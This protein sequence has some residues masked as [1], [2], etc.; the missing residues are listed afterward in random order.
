MKISIHV[1]ISGAVQLNSPLISYGM[2][3]DITSHEN[4]MAQSLI[5]SLISD[6]LKD[7][8]L[9]LYSGA[10][11]LCLQRGWKVYQNKIKRDISSLWLGPDGN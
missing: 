10:A 6:I 5:L 1:L 8:M 7:M 4:R 3:M 2:D 11:L 9:I